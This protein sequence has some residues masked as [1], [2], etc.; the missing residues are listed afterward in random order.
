M[1]TKELCQWLKDLGISD[2]DIKCFEEE[3]IDG[4]LLAEFNEKDL[5]ELGIKKGFIRKKIIIKFKQDI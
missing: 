3:E 2:S 1:T 4:S 5:E